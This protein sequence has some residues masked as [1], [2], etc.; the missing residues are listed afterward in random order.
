MQPDEGIVSQAA[1]ARSSILERD[2]QQ[3]M[4]EL[5]ETSSQAEAL[6]SENTSL[7]EELARTQDRLAALE[8]DHSSTQVSPCSLP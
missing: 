5:E 4:Q 3:K 2:L 1:A 8:K 6:A 7:R